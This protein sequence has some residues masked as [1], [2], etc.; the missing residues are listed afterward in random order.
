[1]VMPAH[2][3]FKITRIF[4]DAYLRASGTLTVKEKIFGPIDMSVENNRCSLDM[5]ICEKFMT[6]NIK[7]VCKRMVD[8]MPLYA[9][10]FKNIQPPL[11]CPVEAG[12]YTVLPVEMDVSIMNLMPLD[13]YIYL[14]NIK[15]SSATANGGKSKKIAWCVTAEIKIE[16]VRIKE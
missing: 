4:T 6:F 9:S 12:N 3:E 1:M 7:E 11:K 5:K 15:I 8:P 13:G 14:T 16:K 2:G 10:V